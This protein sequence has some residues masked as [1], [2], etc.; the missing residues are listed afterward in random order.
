MDPHGDKIV[1][2]E[3]GFRMISGNPFLR[4]PPATS[5]TVT[6]TGSGKPIQPVQMTCATTDGGVSR[7]PQGSDGMHGVG[8]ASTHPV[9]PT[10]PTG[11]GVG[12]PNRASLP[13][14]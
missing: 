6:D 4:S 5:D 14:S 10:Q 9:S 2:W 8:I 13:G 7:W 3:P 12:F 11:D 1:P